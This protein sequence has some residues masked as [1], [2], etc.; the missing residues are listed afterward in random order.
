MSAFGT[1]TR[2]RALALL[3][4]ACAWLG[5]LG[6]RGVS[7][8]GSADAAPLASPLAMLFTDPRSAQAI[9]AA[10]LRT[11]DGAEVPSERMRR[12][13]LGDG[14]TA[15]AAELK[16]AIAVQIRRDFAEGAI[17]MVDGW[18]LSRTEARLCGLAALS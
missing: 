11:I 1:F 2:R 6:T 7:G 13:I 3:V 12:A 9:G 16:R 10:Y 18:M 17:V 15:D 8:I 14:P 5:G 4:S